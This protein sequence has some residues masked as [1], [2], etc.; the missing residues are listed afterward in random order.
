MNKNN[1]PLRLQLDLYRSYIP[2]SYEEMEVG[3]CTP[4]FS[5]KIVEIFNEHEQLVEDNEALN[6]AFKLACLDLIKKSGGDPRD[7]NKLQYLMKQY[8]E[9]SKRPENGSRAIV[10]LLRERKEQLGIS[11]RE[12]VRFCYSYKLPPK[13]LKEIFS[14]KEVTD[15]HLKCISRILGKPVED[16]IEIRDGFSHSEINMLARILGTSNEELSQLFQN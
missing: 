9:K 7:A 5:S 8:M 16:L 4:E 12:F 15:K 3:F 1:Q 14:G 10:Y 6:K 11:N 2:I 13:E